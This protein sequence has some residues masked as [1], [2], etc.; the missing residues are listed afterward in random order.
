MYKIG[1]Y[2]TLTALLVTGCATN[3]I[4]LNKNYGEIRES[5]NETIKKVVSKNL[6]ATGFFL[7]KCRIT[8]ISSGSRIILY[9]TMKYNTAGDY[10]ISLKSRTGTEAFRVFISKDTILINDRIN[11]ELLYGKPNDFERISGLPAEMLKISVGDLFV[12]KPVIENTEDQGSEIKVSDYYEGL[13]IQSVIDKT[14]EKANSVIIK[15]GSPDNYLRIIYS[16][17]REDTYSIPG[18]IEIYDGLK[19]IKIYIEIVKY[20]AP[21]MGDF[22]FVPGEGYSKKLLK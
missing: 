7:Q 22:E 8:S 20:T 1:I 4:R 11:K 13:I 18:K 10:L 21:W 5:G 12:N 14:I 9:F 2:I 19:S 6:T 3:K 16:K 17:H 15:S